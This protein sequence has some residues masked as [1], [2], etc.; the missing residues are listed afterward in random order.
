MKTGAIL[1]FV[2]L[3]FIGCK[4][5]SV[6]TISLAAN[7]KYMGT[8]E[9]TWTSQAYMSSGTGP[10]YSTDS[11]FSIGIYSDGKNTTTF[12]PCPVV[13]FDENDFAYFY[14]GSLTFRNDSIFYICMN[15]GLGGG[16]NESF[17]GKKL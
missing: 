2:L 1:F 17:K 12:G 11:T 8:Y 15:G 7:A 4:K 6:E 16:S 13:Q 3:L 10:V 5:D 14:H 9:G